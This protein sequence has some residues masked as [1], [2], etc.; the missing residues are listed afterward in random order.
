MLCVWMDVCGYHGVCITDAQQCTYVLSLSLCSLHSPILSLCT[1]SL[2]PS[3]AC[4]SSGSLRCGRLH[5]SEVQSP[6][7]RVFAKG[8]TVFEGEKGLYPLS[9]LCEEVISNLKCLR[10][11]LMSCGPGFTS[12]IKGLSP[13]SKHLNY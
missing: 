7:Y 3:P 9:L 5:S 12:T 1:P 8:K 10:Y 6:P 4:Q 2:P 11:C 13:N